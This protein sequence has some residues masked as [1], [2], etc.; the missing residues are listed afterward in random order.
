MTSLL[1]ANG[2]EPP[3][4]TTVTGAV[5][6]FEMHSQAGALAHLGGGRWYNC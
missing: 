2:A 4:G 6:A 5:Q 1:F 3:V